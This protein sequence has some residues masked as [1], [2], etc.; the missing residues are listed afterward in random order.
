MG[1]NTSKYMLLYSLYSWPNVVLCFFGGYLLDTVF[2]IRYT[3]QTMF[4]QFIQS[5]SG[6]YNEGDLW[7]P[8]PLESVKGCE[9]KKTKEREGE[10]ERERERGG[11]KEK[12]TKRG[13]ERK[14][15]KKGDKKEKKIG[16]ST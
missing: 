13:Q 5:L 4:L 6:A 10:Q 14:N 12:M 1:V 11:E 16:Q 9:E 15:D 3:V 7:G 8:G 2:G